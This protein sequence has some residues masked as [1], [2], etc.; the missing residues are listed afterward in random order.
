MINEDNLYMTEN[1]F[2]ILDSFFGDLNFTIKKRLWYRRENDGFIICQFQ[3][4][5]FDTKGSG[6][7]NFGLVFVKK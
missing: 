2:E 5:R 6:F 3:G 1:L 4:F 7:L